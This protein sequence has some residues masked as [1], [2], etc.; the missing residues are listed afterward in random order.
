MTEPSVLAG[1]PVACTV[2]ATGGWQPE[3]DENSGCQVFTG[4]LFWNSPA[5]RA[6]WYEEL[7]RLSCESYE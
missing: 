3:P 2:D 4:I 6:E 7:F 5:A 1:I